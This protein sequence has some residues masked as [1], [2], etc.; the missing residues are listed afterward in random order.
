[1][2]P[3]QEDLVEFLAEN[4]VRVVA[5]LPCYSEKNVNMQRG[6]VITVGIDDKSHLYSS[7]RQRH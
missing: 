3:G 4:K 5:S 7:S 1:M 2:E 6:K